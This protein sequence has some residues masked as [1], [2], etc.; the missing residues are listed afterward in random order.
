MK[1]TSIH[2]IE[3]T[4]RC[5]LQCK[6]CLQSVMTRKREDMNFET[7]RRSLDLC[8]MLWRK[9]AQ[10]EVWLHGL[11][12]SLLHPEFMEYC[13]LARKT[14]PGCQVK[15]STNGLNLTKEHCETLAEIGI[16]LHISIHKPELLGKSPAYAHNTGILEFIGC[17]PVTEA[18]DW[19]GQVDWK[20]HPQE[21]PCGWLLNG[22]A[23]I[24][25][26]GDIA[27]CCVDGNGNEIIGNINQ[28]FE[29]I[30]KIEM[31]PIKLC[32]KCNLTTEPPKE[33]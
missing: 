19:A 29:E 21:T 12:E 2:Q 4:S 25:S 17:N 14:L 15:F 7:F 8:K 9:G 11:G 5:N 27:T 32:E 31:K 30:M 24:L 22:W 20:K 18:N 26:N 23:I 3:V 28:P 13:K 6:Y 1:L 10:H 16:R 33:E